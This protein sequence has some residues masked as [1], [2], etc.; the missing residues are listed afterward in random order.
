MRLEKFRTVGIRTL[1]L[2]LALMATLV[3]LPTDSAQA[4]DPADP[5]SFRAYDVG[6][7]KLTLD[8]QEAP[9]GDIVAERI[10]RLTKVNVQVSPDAAAQKVSIQAIDLHWVYVLRDMVDKIG[11]VI[12]QKA[13]NLLRIERP[14]PITYTF[15]ESDIKEVIDGIVSV[16]GVSVV[17][18]TDEIKGNVSVTLNDVPWLEALR[19]S[20]AAAGPY[21]VLD[22]GF[23]A[24]SIVKKEDLELVSG[25]HR[26]KFLRPPAPYVG[27]VPTQ[28]GGGGGGGAAGGGSGSG[29]G[30]SSGDQ[31]IAGNPYTPTNDPREIE[32]QFRVI[33]ALRSVVEGEGGN[34]TYIDTNNSIIYTGTRPGVDRLEGLIKRL[35]IEPEQ[36]FIDMNFVVTSNSDALELGLQPGNA[37]NGIGFSMSGADALHQLPFNFGADGIAEALSGTAIPSPAAQ[38]ATSYGTLSFTE[39]ANLWKFL[40]RDSSTRVVQAPKLLALDNQ[41]ATIFIGDTVRYARTEATSDENGRLVFGIEEDENSPVNVGFQLLVI[42]HVIPGEQKIMMTVIPQRT[43]LVGQ[44]G[45]VPGFD[46]FVVGQNFIDLPR[47]SANTLVTHMLLRSG[48]TAV[49]GGLLEDRE[50]IAVDKIPFLGDLPGLGLAFQGQRKVTVNEHLL[51]TI[52]PR[53]LYGTDA[54]NCFVTEKL[55]GAAAAVSTEHVDLHTRAIRSPG[56]ASSPST[57]SS[58]HPGTVVAPLPPAPAA[59]RVPMGPSGR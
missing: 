28:S 18:N 51:I 22:N 34:V 32:D 42:P 33:A 23:G 1:V 56:A 21:V 8:V 40:Q 59:P 31:V 20:V 19:M 29:G 11:G 52:T 16:A 27:V 48:E 24:Y 6:D 37:G 7:G 39:T 26:F 25:Y 45:A 55:L 43:T 47:V 9:F 10:Q 36:V 30:S 2:A 49:I 44:G 15:K 46:R 12:V 5:D 17:F 14:T 38:P 4:N 50:E 35:D 58:T 54:A 3:A 53:I 41:A 13:P 57:G